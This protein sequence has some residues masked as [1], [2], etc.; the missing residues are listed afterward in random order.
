[1]YKGCTLSAQSTY[2]QPYFDE[3]GKSPGQ[4]TISHDIAPLIVH[5]EAFLL[6]VR[7][8]QIL[9]WNVDLDVDGN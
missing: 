7:L 2:F 4:Y 1:M 8:T 5:F 6:V 3:E 9:W